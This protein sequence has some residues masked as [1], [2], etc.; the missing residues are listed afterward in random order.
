MYYV[1]LRAYGL[2]AGSRAFLK[3]ATPLGN[4]HR[5]SKMPRR[6]PLLATDLD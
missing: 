1:R 6:G 2:N 3:L 4:S 5:A